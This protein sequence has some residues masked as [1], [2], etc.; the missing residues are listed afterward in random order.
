[1]S[2]QTEQMSGGFEVGLHKLVVIFSSI[3]NFMCPS[4][5]ASLERISQIFPIIISADPSCTVLIFPDEDV[6]AAS[7]RDGESPQSRSSADLRPA[8]VPCLALI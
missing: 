7:D 1:M 2:T 4:M 3:K 5:F 6:A 8:A